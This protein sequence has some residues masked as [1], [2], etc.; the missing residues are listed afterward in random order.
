MGCRLSAADSR[1]P[2][3]ASPAGVTNIRPLDAEAA[4]RGCG[5][6]GGGGADELGGG[7]PNMRGLPTGLGNS[8][9]HLLV[10][11]DT[12]YM[13]LTHNLDFFGNSTSLNAPCTSCWQ[14]LYSAES[15]NKSTIAYVSFK[16]ASF[17]A[18]VAQKWSTFVFVLRFA[19]CFVRALSKAVALASS[20][21]HVFGRG[22]PL[23]E[24]HQRDRRRCCGYHLSTK[25]N[26]TSFCRCRCNRWCY[27]YKGRRTLINPLFPRKVFPREKIR[28]LITWGWVGVEMPPFPLIYS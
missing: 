12:W 10:S 28:R 1:V 9:A 22:P 3:A 18:P 4:S 24:A 17:K 23:L 27:S 25:R 11:K 13:F 15:T 7:G 19:S 2:A 20:G 14:V 16:A 8:V 26:T 5:C 6:E 21:I